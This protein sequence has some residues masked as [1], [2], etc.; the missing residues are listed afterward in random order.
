MEFRPV[1]PCCVRIVSRVYLYTVLSGTANPPYS[2]G[3]CRTVCI[4]ITGLLLY[5]KLFG[6]V[7]KHGSKVS[8]LVRQ[9]HRKRRSLAIS[10]IGC[11]TT[12]LECA[13]D[14][15]ISRCIV[16][17]SDDHLLTSTDPLTRKAYSNAAMLRDASL[18][19]TP[20]RAAEVGR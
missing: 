5:R 15:L 9:G 3:C 12:F 19:V 18:A 8:L 17:S 7:R 13:Y 10:G 16:F 20:K 2:D 4:T 11:S 14:D 1:R 6:D